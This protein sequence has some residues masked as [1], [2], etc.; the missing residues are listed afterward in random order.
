MGKKKKGQMNARSSLPLDFLL[1]EKINSICLSNSK[2]GFLLVSVKSISSDTEFRFIPVDRIHEVQKEIFVYCC[3]SS[4][5]NSVWLIVGTQKL[6][7]E[8][9][10]GTGRHKIT[11]SMKSGKSLN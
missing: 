10:N 8:Q 3:I 6:F 1:I 7:V 2:L 11:E 5:S 9:I 4:I